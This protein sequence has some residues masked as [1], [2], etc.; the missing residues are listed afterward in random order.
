MKELPQDLEK[1]RAR[2]SLTG[3][4]SFPPPPP[5]PDTALSSPPLDHTY[6]AP[7]RPFK[8]KPSEE[9]SSRAR[10][11][12]AKPPPLSASFDA[13]V[14]DEVTPGYDVVSKPKRAREKKTSS[15]ELAT[16]K[17]SPNKQKSLPDHGSLQLS[18]TAFGMQKDERAKSARSTYIPRSPHLYEAVPDEVLDSNRQTTESARASAIV[19]PRHAHIYESPE[20]VRKKV[21]RKGPTSKKR[22]PP[23]APPATPAKPDQAV[24]TV[25]SDNG[26]SPNGTAQ[27]RTA[28][29]TSASSMASP[30]TEIASN[31]M[32]YLSTNMAGKRLTV[33]IQYKEE[34][35]ER[36]SKEPKFLFNKGRLSHFIHVS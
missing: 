26:D 13:D 11:P 24:S 27:L 9:P 1:Q 2:L 16:N 31:P 36:D 12:P 8:S 17:L 35:E 18:P 30:V 32:A 10:K 6:E 19:V 29:N 23:P 7:P 33:D 22:P 20:E 15:S 14:E 25:T 28:A 3:P 5:P 34:E 21:R 4:P